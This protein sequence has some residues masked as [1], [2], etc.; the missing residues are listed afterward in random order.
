MAAPIIPLVLL[1]VGIL[2]LRS[3]RRRTTKKTSDSSEEPTIRTVVFVPPQSE[4]PSG[5]PGEPGEPRDPGLSCDA[6]DGAA[7]WDDQGHCKT[8]WIDGTTDQ[9]IEALLLEQWEARGRPTFSELCLAVP[10]PTG[11]EFAPPKD[12]PLFVEIVAAAL[13]GYYGIGAVFP[14]VEP[15]GSDDP[16]SPFWVQE[17]WQRATAIARGIL[18]E[19]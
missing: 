9:A 7:A 14:P 2:A 3:Q 8:F 11:G 15:R 5:E 12:S 10:D 6:D 13:Q 19:M 18:C 1:G 4:E 16:R 17:T